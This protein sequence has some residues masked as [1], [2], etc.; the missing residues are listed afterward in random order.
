MRPT[1]I[2]RTNPANPPNYHL[3]HFAVKECASVH[4]NNARFK[5]AFEQLKGPNPHLFGVLLHGC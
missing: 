5:E 1:D 2:E 3:T 4:L